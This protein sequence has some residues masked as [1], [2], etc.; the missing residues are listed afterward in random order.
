MPFDGPGAEEYLGPDLH[1]GAAVDGEPGDVRLPGG[2]L[3]DLLDRPLAHRV[4]GGQQLTPGPPGERLDAH[5]GEQAMG[6]PQLGAGVPAPVLAAQ[7]FAVHEVGAGHGRAHA[8]TA[9]PLDRLAIA[10]LGGPTL[11]QRGTAAR[12]R[13]KRPV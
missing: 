9:E 11:T 10:V 7:P 3:A 2:E 5:R 13:A 4:S 12:L 6:G 1:V 8:G